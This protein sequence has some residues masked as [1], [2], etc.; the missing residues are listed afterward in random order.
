MLK[1]EVVILTNNRR[2]FDKNVT[3]AKGISTLKLKALLVTHS[4][5]FVMVK[6]SLQR[7]T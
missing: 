4:G 1:E 7:L 2:R 5:D 6:F 3:T